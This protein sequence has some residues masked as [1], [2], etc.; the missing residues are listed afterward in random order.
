[1]DGRALTIAICVGAAVSGGL[2]AITAAITNSEDIAR[3]FLL[4]VMS[5]WF[6]GLAV[7]IFL[8]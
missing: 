5:S 2:M 6:S 4:I 1:M 8:R 3:I 7:Y